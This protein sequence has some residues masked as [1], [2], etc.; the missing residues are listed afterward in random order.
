MRVAHLIHYQLTGQ[1][2]LLF[3]VVLQ[4]LLIY[5]NHV[6]GKKIPKFDPFIPYS[7]LIF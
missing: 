4:S 3:H 1:N 5:G 2:G 6:L 7:T